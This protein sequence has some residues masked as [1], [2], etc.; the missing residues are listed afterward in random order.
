MT[1][2]QRRGAIVGGVVGWLASIFLGIAVG[3]SR[4]FLMRWVAGALI[5]SYLGQRLATKI[6][7][8]FNTSTLGQV[9]LDDRYIS[10]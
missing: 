10:I 7:G 8:R 2:L 5:G 3:G 4:R 9:E 6:E 1:T